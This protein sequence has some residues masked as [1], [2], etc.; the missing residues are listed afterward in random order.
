[1]VIG[2][3]IDACGAVGECPINGRLSL[4][5]CCKF[6]ASNDRA[7]LLSRACMVDKLN[8]TISVKPIRFGFW[9]KPTA[10]YLCSEGMMY[11]VPRG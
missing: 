3:H 11:G 1:M 10:L 6:C 7:N 2:L 5:I 4:R 9:Q 8:F